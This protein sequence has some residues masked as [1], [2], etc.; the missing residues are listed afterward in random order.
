MCFVWIPAARAETEGA[1]ITTPAIQN[2]CDYL[3]KKTDDERQ[4]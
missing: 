3:R 2:M 1:L 4:A